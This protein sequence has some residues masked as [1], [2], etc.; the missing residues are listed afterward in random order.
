MQKP[1][2]FSWETS[3]FQTGIP[4]TSCAA[5]SKFLGLLLSRGLQLCFWLVWGCSTQ[6]SQLLLWVWALKEKKVNHWC[7]PVFFLFNFCTLWLHLFFFFLLL[8]PFCVWCC[9]V[10]I[11]PCQT[12]W[13]MFV[14]FSK[15]VVIRSW[16]LKHETRWRSSVRDAASALAESLAADEGS[17]RRENSCFS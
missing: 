6:N 3:Q 10:G 12:L 5:L 9:A 1:N 17:R 2:W 4:E 11:W 7:L 8:Y 13:R 14:N 15:L 16:M